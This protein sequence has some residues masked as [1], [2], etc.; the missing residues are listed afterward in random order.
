MEPVWIEI[1]LGLGGNVGDAP[2][3]IAEALRILAAREKI[4][5][6][7]VS[8]IYRTPPWGP[9]AQAD[10]ANAC[11]LA[12]TTLDPRALLNEVK[13]V[14]ILLGREPGLRWGPRRID[15][16]ILFYAGLSVDAPDLVIPHASLFE[17]AFVL[18]PLAEIAPDLVIGGKRVADAAAAIAQEGV[19]RWETR[20]PAEG[21]A[22]D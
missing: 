7:R 8:A 19:T 9:V 21:M 16:D 1:A 5:I 2:G 3:A 18:V 11:A 4:R 22:E 14:E 13:A 15:I 17:R 10:F 20:G 6:G 12:Q